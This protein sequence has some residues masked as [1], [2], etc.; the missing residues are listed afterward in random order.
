MRGK[1]G[2]GGGQRA[3]NRWV[4]GTGG[5][6]SSQ[7]E[8]GEKPV[9]REG[10]TIMTTAT[11]EKTPAKVASPAE[12]VAARKEFLRKEKEFTRLRDGLSRQRREL[13]WE[14]VE[15]QYMF[16]GANGKET[17]AD[18]FDGRSQLIIYHFM[19]GPGWKEGCPS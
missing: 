6:S 10:V 17:L 19:F 8:G 15:K 18:L 1:R 13:A 12:W 7:E 11:M 5:K 4:D 16:E 9:E 14:K 3:F 2:S